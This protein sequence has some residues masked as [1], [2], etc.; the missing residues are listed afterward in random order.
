MPFHMAIFS[1]RTPEEW[2][3]FTGDP[4]GRLRKSQEIVAEHQAEMVGMWWDDD[5]QVGYV[6]LAGSTD[7]DETQALL[8]KL[9]CEPGAKRLLT[10]AEKNAR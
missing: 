5:E 7:P 8:K 6:L 9:G 1:D 4:H 3:K 10:A 2:K